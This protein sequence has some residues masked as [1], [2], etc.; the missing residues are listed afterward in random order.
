MAKF[1]KVTTEY[2]GDEH[3]EFAQSMLI[4]VERIVSVR[5]VGKVFGKD[6]RVMIRFERSASLFEGTEEV[7]VKESLEEIEA[8]LSS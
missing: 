7:E 1:I 6:K 5:T 8:L 3:T 2:L 4:S